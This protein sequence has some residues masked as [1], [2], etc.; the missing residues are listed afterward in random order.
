M[1]V[2]AESA[3]A[4]WL[5]SHPDVLLTRPSHEL[6]SPKLSAATRTRSRTKTKARH[7]VG[8]ACAECGY[9]RNYAALEFHHLTTSNS[10]TGRVVSFGVTSARDRCEAASDHAAPEHRCR[11]L[12]RRDETF[13]QCVWTRSRQTRSLT[14]AHRNAQAIVDMRPRCRGTTQSVEA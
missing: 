2:P 4:S 10:S 11:C 5:Q 3:S 1:G 6:P 14:P 7:R 12:A 13:R 8:R 9:Q